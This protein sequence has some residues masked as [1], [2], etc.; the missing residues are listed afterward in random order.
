MGL[1]SARCRAQGSSGVR[2]SFQA[3]FLTHPPTP[4]PKQRTGEPASGSLATKR[5]P[6]RVKRFGLQSLLRQLRNK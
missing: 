3:P 5:H 6:W 4:P 2:E 1:L